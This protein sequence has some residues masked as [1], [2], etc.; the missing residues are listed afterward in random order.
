[1]NGHA[2]YKPVG[3]RGGS[4]GAYCERTI[5]R[6]HKAGYVRRKPLRRG[7]QTFWLYSV[8]DAK[9]VASGQ[10][11]LIKSRRET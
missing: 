11:A 5:R 7:L 4:G 3:G 9:R 8:S 10:G 6:W 2:G 1:M